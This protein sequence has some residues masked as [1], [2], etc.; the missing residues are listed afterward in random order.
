M[1]R[2]T[3]IGGV[4]FKANDPQQLR[5]WYR[6]HLG[7]DVQSWGGASFECREAE[8][9]ER[10][11]QTVWSIFPADT[12]YFDPSRAPFMINFRVDDLNRVLDQLRAEGVEV[13][14]R[15][16]ES[17]FGRFGWAMDGEGNRVELWEPPP[18]RQD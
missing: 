17:E 15:I 3:G 6:R 2:V 14:A 16:E 10:R 4:F 5:E 9:P 1:E 8:R 11:G 13:D 18:Q 12:K 7:I